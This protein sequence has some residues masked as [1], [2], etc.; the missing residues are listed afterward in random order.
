MPFKLRKPPVIEVWARA[1]MVPAPES[2][3]DWREAGA[4]LNSY[5]AELT[6]SEKLPA[7]TPQATGF[8]GDIPTELTIHVEPRYLRVRN[9]D[10]S[11]VVQ[12]GRHELVIAHGRTEDQPYPGF[13]AI[14][15]SFLDGIDRYC[16]RFPVADVESAELHY[17]D[18]V[19]I[20][21]LYAKGLPPGD[22]FEGAPDLP[23][24]PFGGL[25]KVSW[26]FAFSC[27]GS[28]DSAQLSIE[29]LAPDM[30]SDDG[31]FRIDWHIT[32]PEVGRDRAGIAARLQ[33]AHEYLKTCFQHVCKPIVWELFEPV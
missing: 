19:I 23:L 17:V 5:K 1:N 20:P 7:F 3:W 22:Y 2:E 30:E 21:E 26:S 15:G 24:T 25:A 8:D 16:D 4:F 18:L 10:R 31:R 13:D 14:S 32:C 27:P 12:I 11:K 28:Q 33:V 6:F 29:L 9:E